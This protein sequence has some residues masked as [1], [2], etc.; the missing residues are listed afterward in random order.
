MMS[1][2]IVLACIAGSANLIDNAVTHA[3]GAYAAAMGYKTF[4]AL[5]PSRSDVSRLIASSRVSSRLQ[6]LNR[7]K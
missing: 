7:T 5:R 3:N 1:A 4:G 6:K 2:A